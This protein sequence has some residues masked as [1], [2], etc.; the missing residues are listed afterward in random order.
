[1]NAQ[2]APYIVLLATLFGTSLV[3]SRF[4]VGQISPMT[5]TGLRLALT[6]L[7][8]V[9]VYLLALGGPRWPTGG[10]LWRRAA[11]LGLFDTAL[12][13]SFMVLSLQYQS[14]GLTAILATVGPAITVLLAHFFLADERL[15][16]RKAAGVALAFG[17]AV[18]L[19]V[20]GE[21]GLPDVRQTDPVGYLLVLGAMISA[22]AMTVYTRRWM[23]GFDSFQIT[24]VRMFVATLVVMPLSLLLVGFDL[25]QV[26]WQGYTALGY[27]ALI[28]TFFGFWLLIHV[29]QRFGATAAAT[30]LYLSPVVTGL[31]GV[32]VL[33]ETITV[34]MAAG[35]VLIAAGIALLRQRPGDGT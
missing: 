9:L 26:T 21:S 17:G 35:I 12:P 25:S 33:G 27:G 34:G 32:L 5:Y 29:V 20:L 30:T 16:L 18:L 15:S 22:S 24:S 3:A 14:S 1:M 4:G 31:G 11:L 28:G 19:G 6:S 13:M 8:H 2:S 10:Q 7:G 23:R